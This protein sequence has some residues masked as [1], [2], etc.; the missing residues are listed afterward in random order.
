MKFVFDVTHFHLCFRKDSV[1]PTV[2]NLLLGRPVMGHMYI[3]RISLDD[4]P[5]DEE[6]A[7]LWLRDLYNK[8]VSLTFGCSLTLLVI[9]LS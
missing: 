4:V 3:E 8:K 1:K 6:K 2:M 5:E 9:G 7:S